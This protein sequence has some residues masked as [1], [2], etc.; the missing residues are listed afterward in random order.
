MG[1]NRSIWA[2][3]TKIGVEARFGIKQPIRT[4]RLFSQIYTKKSQVW[5]FGIDLEQI[6]PFQKF[7]YLGV[8]A[9][10]RILA[11]TQYGTILYIGYV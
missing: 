6:W 5:A 7:G 8:W 10:K 4:C 3:G 1:E 2:F 11:G 9:K